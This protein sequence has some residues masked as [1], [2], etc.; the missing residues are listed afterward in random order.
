MLAVQL[1][2]IQACSFHQQDYLRT[3][4]FNCLDHFKIALLAGLLVRC[5]IEQKYKLFGVKDRWLRDEVNK[6]VQVFE[7]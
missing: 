7:T 3:S 5:L 2:L 6:D 4:E 1:H